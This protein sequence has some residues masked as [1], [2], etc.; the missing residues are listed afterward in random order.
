M[1]ASS[2][3]RSSATSALASLM[4]GLLIGSNALAGPV[5]IPPGNLPGSRQGTQP[6]ADPEAV[7]K[8]ILGVTLPLSVEDPT[9]AKIRKGLLAAWDKFREGDREGCL[10]DMKAVCQ[11]HPQVPPA[12]LMQARILLATRDAAGGRALLEEAALDHADSPDLMLTFGELAVSERRWM[13]ASAHF[14]RARELLE[15]A[16]EAGN[17]L[18][19]TNQR[20]RLAS[21]QAAVAEGRKRW[22]KAEELL[23]KLLEEDPE[24]ASTHRRLGRALFEQGDPREALEEFQA[25]A[26]LQEDLEFPALTVARLFDAAGEEKAEQTKQWMEY[27]VK[28]GAEESKVLTNVALWHLRND[29]TATASKLIDDLEKLPGTDPLDV[30]SYRGLIAQYQGDMAQAEKYFDQVNRERPSDFA[31]ANQLAMVLAESRDEQKLQKAL[32]LA[33]T[34]T[35]QRPQSAE[36]AATLGWVQ[37]R[38]GKV[39]E[40]KKVLDAVLRSGRATPDALF[41]AG[42]ML[43]SLGKPE[44]AE[45]LLSQSLKA[46]SLFLNRRS[47][48]KKLAQVKALTASTEN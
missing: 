28:V 27:A 7:L 13:E 11:E 20:G 37:Y 43:A 22:E 16:K 41:F 12:K 35:K 47:A 5:V 19:G 9:A 46:R 48:E 2:L 3:S 24:N 6:Q 17:E 45:K 4:V 39:D 14:E 38:L 30:A 23:K 36:L 15:Q 26:E 18:V 34:N 44:Q 42:H 40:A 10:D 1:K 33:T 21:G 29:D 8:N 25:A 32:R 31:V